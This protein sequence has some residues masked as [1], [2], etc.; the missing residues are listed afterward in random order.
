M[1]NEYDSWLTKL[2]KY[3]ICPVHPFPQSPK[4]SINTSFIH[5]FCKARCYAWIF[6]T[7]TKEVSVLTTFL[8]P[9]GRYHYLR[10]PIDLS[11]SSDEWCR[12]SDW[13]VEGLPWTKKMVDDILKWEPN[14]QELESEIAAVLQRFSE[15]NVTISKSKFEIG[16]RC[17]SQA[18][19]LPKREY[20][21]NPSA[22][23]PCQNF[24]FPHPNLFDHS[25][26]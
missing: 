1:G 24:L 6:P 25:W 12:H 15:L 10:A 26:V 19:S 20:V 8:L 11:A 18:L 22:Q 17:H 16:N 13:V 9:S 5:L 3:V 4:C 14:I 23:M 2:D 7:H 21:P